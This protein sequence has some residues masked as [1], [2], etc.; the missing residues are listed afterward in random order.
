MNEKPHIRLKF[1]ESPAEA[2][3]PVPAAKVA[4]KTSPAAKAPKPKPKPRPPTVGTE[5]LLVKCGHTIVFDLY[6]K[7]SFRDQRRQKEASRDCPPCRQARVQAE[8]IAHKERRA[9]KAVT[10]AATFAKSLKPR[11]P[12]GARFAATYDATQVQWTG[13]L[14]IEGSTFEQRASSLN[15][16]LHR[17]D[18][19]YRAAMATAAVVDQEPS[20]VAP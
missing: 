7:D 9:R 12:D 19:V 4:A 18:D 5:V 1:R 14:T 10:K 17:L 15:K 8:A 6:A 2:V 13:T 20:A 11:L 3:A 16:L